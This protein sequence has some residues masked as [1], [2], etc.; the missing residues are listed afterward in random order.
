MMKYLQQKKYLMNIM[1][2]MSKYEKTNISFE[3]WH[4]FKLFVANKYKQKDIHHILCT[5]KEKIIKFLSSFHS[6]KGIF[7]FFVIV[8]FK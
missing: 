3:A 8:V 5:N 2:L 6:E 7:F 1:C 4:I